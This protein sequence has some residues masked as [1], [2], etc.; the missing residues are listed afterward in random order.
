MQLALAYQNIELANGRRGG[1]STTS[2]LLYYVTAHAMQR[3]YDEDKAE[4]VRGNGNH[5]NKALMLGCA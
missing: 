3:R 5:K 4:N 2:S 1:P